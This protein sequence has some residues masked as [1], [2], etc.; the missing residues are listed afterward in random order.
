MTRVRVKFFALARDLAACAEAE[1]TV[2]D[3]TYVKDMLAVLSVSYPALHKLGPYMRIA[4]NCEYV[5][6]EYLLHQD[7]EVALIPPVSG[8]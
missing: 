5:S 4:V 6:G 1:L 3:N 8:G 7:D 2:P